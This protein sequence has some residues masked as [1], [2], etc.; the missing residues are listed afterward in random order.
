MSIKSGLL[1]ALVTVILILAFGNDW[2]AEKVQEADGSTAFTQAA[3]VIPLHWG[4][5]IQ[6][7]G[8]GATIGRLVVMVLL[9]VVL[10]A[11]AGR[12]RPLAA[13]VGGWGAFLMATVVSMGL[14]AFMAEEGSSDSNVGFFFGAGADGLDQFTATSIFGAPSGLFLGWLVG[15]AVMVGSL[16]RESAAT[17]PPSAWEQPPSGSPFA[18]AP[19]GGPHGA[20]ASYGNPAPPGTESSPFGTPPGPPPAP[21]TAAPPPHPGA[22]P[23]DGPVIG[24]PPDRTQVQGQPPVDPP[25]PGQ[26]P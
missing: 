12:A 20:P 7:G 8:T 13:F 5:E 14:Y 16:Q 6:D 19:P 1:A 23:A 24:T 4:D 25:P 22:P 2:A 21:A 10:G 11:I 26:Q 3:V 18:P 9:T 15:L 17:L